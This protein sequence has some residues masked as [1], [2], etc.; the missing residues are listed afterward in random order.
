MNLSDD[1][2]MAI[3]H[4][5]TRGKTRHVLPILRAVAEAAVRADRA[6]AEPVGEVIEH[7]RNTHYK[8]RSRW[9]LPDGTKLYTRP[10]PV[11]V[12]EGMVLVPIKP[13]ARMLDYAVSFALNVGPAQSGGWTEYARRMWET[14]VCATA[15][16]SPS[17]SQNAE[18][19]TRQPGCVDEIAKRDRIGELEAELAELS[20][21]YQRL[22]SQ[23]EALYR[24]LHGTGEKTQHCT[25]CKRSLP[26][27]RFDKSDR[28]TRLGVVYVCREC[29]ARRVSPCSAHGAFHD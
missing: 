21:S 12:P 22:M 24:Q 18:N 7:V 4:G 27:D 20:D 11:A 10:Q 23:R 2:L 14:M 19:R 5:D 26:L 17:C 6:Q 29:E 25:G 3:W 28:P 13:T 1:E 8:L 9:H 15:P 16:A